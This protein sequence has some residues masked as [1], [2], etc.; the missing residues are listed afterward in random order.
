[1]ALSKTP[2][3]MRCPYADEVL[4]AAEAEIALTLRRVAEMPEG[5]A[6]EA[7]AIRAD[8]LDRFIALTP[9][10]TLVGAAVKLRRLLDPETGL[11]VGSNALDVAALA[12]VLAL[13]TSV[14]GP[15]KHAT[16]PTCDS[17]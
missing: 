3:R 17:D 15:P 13:L 7:L 2:P 9:P 14:T 5:D 11:R 12:Q 4:I 16:R 8:A 1:M 6:S 10:S